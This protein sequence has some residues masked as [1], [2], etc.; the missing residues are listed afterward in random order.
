MI[1]T[2]STAG[3]DGRGNYPSKEQLLLLDENGW[4]DLSNYADYTI[5]IS[6]DE[7][8]LR[9]RLI[10]RRMK[11]GVPEEAAIRFVDFSDMPNVRLC[12]QKSKKADCSLRIDADNEYHMDC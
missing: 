9:K 3:D 8:L 1:C 5:F 10:D 12:L 6:A 2:P 11:T 7:A 4:R